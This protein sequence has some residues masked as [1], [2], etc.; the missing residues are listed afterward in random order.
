M[1]CVVSGI[2][3]PGSEVVWWKSVVE[4][5]SQMKWLRSA[6]QFRPTLTLLLTVA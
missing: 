3:E 1:W 5:G 2:V 6:I 4:L